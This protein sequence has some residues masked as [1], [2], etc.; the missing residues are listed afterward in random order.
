MKTKTYL[1]HIDGLRAFAILAVVLFHTFPSVV[2]GGFTGVDIFFVI[3]GFLITRLILLDLQAERFSLA[4]FWLRRVRRLFPHLLLMLFFV[5]LTGWWILFDFEFKELGQQA[6][7]GI[8]FTSNFLFAKQAGYFD[9]NAALKPLLHLWSLGIE[10]Q[11]YILLPLVILTFGVRHLG[12]ILGLLLAASFLCSVYWVQEHRIHAFYLPDSRMWEL[13]I[14]CILAYLHTK[15][16]PFFKNAGSIPVFAL[17]LI[18]LLTAVVY[19]SEITP[20]PGMW[21]LLP[22]LGAAAVI[23]TPNNYLSAMIFENRLMVQLGKLSYPLYLWHWPLLV[24]RKMMNTD[25]AASGVLCLLLALLLSVMAEWLV[26]SISFQRK[27]VWL[28]TAAVSATIGFTSFQAYSERLYPYSH[29]LN[30]SD[31][32]RAFSDWGFPP[33]NP[34]IVPYKNRGFYFLG[35][36]VN[37]DTVVFIGDSNIEQYGPTVE[38][39]IL[40]DDHRSAIFAT[41]GGCAPFRNFWRTDADWCNNLVETAEEFIRENKIKHVVLGAFWRGYYVESQ[42]FLMINGERVF[43]G[44]EGA[45]FDIWLGELRKQIQDYRKAGISVYLVGNT[46]VAAL[47]NPKFIINRNVFQNIFEK[48]ITEVPLR[49]VDQQVHVINRKLAAVAQDAGA[50]Y[51]SPIPELCPNDSCPN[52]GIEGPIYID[53]AH[54]RP[55]RARQLKFLETVF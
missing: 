9:V 50:V 46:P 23:A 12:K 36:E 18:A 10:E 40:T 13:L 55:Y 3:S 52:W 43:M 38:A 21:A 1:P 22:T 47:L 11:F 4:G 32:T 31:V 17:G 14:G 26:R 29:R 33:K 45:N 39:A 54:L 53:A 35:K 6:L 25:S 16:K 41:G 44:G 30:F 2:P 34:Q 24:F 37:S 51:L 7:A 20:F 27:S 19:F 42:H 28:T 49:D 15:N 5:L 48:Q 8:T